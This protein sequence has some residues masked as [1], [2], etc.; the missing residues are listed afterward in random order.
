M[1]Y[2]GSKILINKSRQALL[3]A[4]YLPFIHYTHI[5]HIKLSVYLYKAL[6]YVIELCEYDNKA[7]CNC[8]KCDWIAN[9]I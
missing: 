7:S 9:K 6:A 4:K 5:A 1:F 2:F 3:S 8:H